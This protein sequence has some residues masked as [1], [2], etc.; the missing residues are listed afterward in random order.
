LSVAKL[1]LLASG[2]G[3]TGY[4]LAVGSRIRDL[5]HDVKRIYVVPRGDL[6]SMA[7][8]H[9]AD[10]DAEIVEVTK[11]LHPFE[12]YRRALTRL[13]QALL[14]TLRNIDDDAL[15]FCTGSN[16]GLLPSLI[17]KYLHKLPV[18]CVEDVFRFK[19]G[20]RT[21]RILHKYAAATV[22]LQWPEQQVLYRT[23]SLY[24]GL[25]YEKPLYT[26]KNGGYILVTTGTTVNKH[27]IK[28]LLKTRLENIVVQTGAINPEL[29]RRK[30]WRAFKFHPD[31]DRLIA[32]ASLVIS[33]PGV[34]VINATQA[35]SKPAVIVHNP[36]FTL[37]A[38]SEE[39]E[40][41]AEKLGIPAVDP[42]KVTPQ[43]FERIVEDSMKLKPRIY[44]DGALFIAKHLIRTFHALCS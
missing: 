21:V 19:H 38:S 12:P 44:P 32:E 8:I 10:P 4:A 25:I 36:D 16:H 30:G 41:V 23:R 40:R 37:T 11:P 9:R 1:I 14:D 7:R 31:I 17:S 34:T 6:W 3:H 39:I 28:L 18:Y 33:S 24:A 29:L 2:G 22:F 27:L 20:S 13:L 15:V 5:K 42:R 26:P 35:Y 43:E